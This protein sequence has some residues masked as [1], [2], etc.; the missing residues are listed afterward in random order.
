VRRYR[1]PTDQG[2]DLLDGL[3]PGNVARIRYGRVCGA[4]ADDD[5]RLL[6]DC[7]VA[8]NDER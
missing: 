3:L 4:M 2:I 7:C 6:A 8:N 1:L 5:G